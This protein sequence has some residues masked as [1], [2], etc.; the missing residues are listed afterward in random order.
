MERM[1]ALDAAF[2][3]NEQHRTPLHIASM[4]ILD[5]PAPSLDDLRAL[6]DAKLDQ[7]PRYRQRVRTVPLGL[8]LPIWVDDET[9]D[10]DNHLRH[11]AVPQPGGAAELRDTAARILE[12]SLNLR[13]PP[14]E[15]W[16]VEGLAGGRWALIAKM[17]HCVVDG[18]GAADLMAALFDLQPAPPPL[19]TASPWRPEPGPSGTALLEDALLDHLTRP[20]HTLIDLVRHRGGIGTGLLHGL[21]GS[22][23]RVARRKPESLSRP[24]G[25]H[26]RWVWQAVG[27]REV[28]TIRATLG[29]TVNDVVLAAATCG[30]RELLTAR[31][32]LRPTSVV[33]TL[34]P[35]S[36]RGEAEHGVMTN[37]IS[38][39]I[40]DLPCH[41]ADAAR[42]LL[43]IRSQT[44][45]LKQ[46]HQAVSGEVLLQVAA[47]APVLIP[48]ESRAAFAIAKPLFESVVTNVPGPPFP[49]YVLG[50]E[51]VELYPYVPIAAGVQVSIGVLSYCGKLYLGITADLDSAPDLDVL[52]KG[53]ESGFAELLDQA[54]A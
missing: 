13:H 2:F 51:A 21:P 23:E 12:R 50:R 49:L 11:T 16:L 8:G 25:P 38:A 20:A 26:R 24:I 27:L 3:F 7:L 48:L 32:D 4:T 9:F 30:F 34:M 10:L 18:V 17:H 41:E 42:R 31:R 28:D 54:T 29:G 46:T 43:H 6:T 33:R 52:A 15:L 36:V 19:P 44:E 14:W 53:I 40:V 39:V 47:L 35:V 22:I 1:S 37:R 45:E 5:G